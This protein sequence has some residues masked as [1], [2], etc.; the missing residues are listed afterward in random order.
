MKGATHAGGAVVDQEEVKRFAARLVDLFTGAILTKLVDIAYRTGLLEAA[1]LGPATSHELAQRARL[2]ERYV[3]EWLG[4]MVT[5]GVMMHDPT[6]DRYTLP[7]EHALLLTGAGSRNLAPMSRIIDHFGTHLDELERCFREGG[8]I[9]YERFRPQFTE[10]MDDVWRRIYDEQLIDG[11]LRPVPELVA[12]LGAGCRV[13]D[14]GCGT[15]HA[16]NVM[17]RAFP[18]SNF[19]GYDIAEDA[20]ARGHAEAVAIDL[21]NAIFQVLDA[22]KLP[23]KAPFDVITAFD[24]IHDQV[25]PELVLQRV[26]EALSPSGIFFMVDFKFS[27]HIDKNVGNPFAPFYYG[28]STMHCMTVSLAEGGAGL[29]T[30]WGQEKARE[31]LGAAGFGSVEVLDCPRPQN[32]IYVCRH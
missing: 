16:V 24:A 23:A 29:G 12:K 11:F 14:I 15:G 13:A 27:S 4:A 21:P 1:A 22:T 5:S 9:P 2:N 30:V 31:M 10:G 20:I 28:I 17:A 18:K 32:C 26:Y 6:S 8:G 3:R 19:T 7:G 25:A